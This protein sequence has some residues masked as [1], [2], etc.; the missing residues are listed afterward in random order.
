[1]PSNNKVA[2]TAAGVVAAAGL[3]AGGTAIAF[4]ASPSASSS[5]SQGGY[6]G[7]RGPG[8]PEGQ[9]RGG[10]NHTPV[11]GS[12]LTKVT[13]AVTAKNSAYKITQVMKDE[14]GSYDVFAT[15]SGSTVMLEVSKD[16]KTITERTGGMHGG[17]G[18]G[19]GMGGGKDTAVTGAEKT[20][21]V[22]AVKAKDSAVTITE[23]RKDPDGSYDALGTKSG[24]P[25]FYDVSKDLKT[26]TANTMIKGGFGGRH[27]DGDMGGGY[28]QP[29]PTP[30]ASTTS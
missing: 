22:D 17:P 29:A 10:H 9:G 8:G 11:T 1:M 26:V 2:M 6:G 12:E 20:K 15:K 14:D 21:V 3:V 25:V 7:M 24:A 27:H 5:P 19:R 18:G 4:A 30:S 28:G 23:V 16:L 13:N